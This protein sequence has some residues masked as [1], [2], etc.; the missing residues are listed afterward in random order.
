MWFYVQMW[1]PVLTIAFAAALCLG[2]VSFIVSA[3]K[4]HP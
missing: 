2:V 4:P 1:S 3:P